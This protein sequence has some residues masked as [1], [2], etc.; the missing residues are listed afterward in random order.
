MWARCSDKKRKLHDMDDT[1]AINLAKSRFR[2]GFKLGD[3]EQI[4]SIYADAFVDMSFGMPSFYSRDSKDVFRARL[5]R[6]FREYNAEMALNII[7]VALNGDRAMD[8][9]WHIL[10]LTSKTSGE[11]LLVRTR[12]FET[13]KRDA[14]KGWLITSF[15]DNLDQTPQLPEELISKLESTCPTAMVTRLPDDGS[16]SAAKECSSDAR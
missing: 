16:R 11:K 13:W 4:L 15:I 8:R 7:D 3:E 5:K 12:Y 9:G 1:Y 2:E 14:A 6:L 10:T